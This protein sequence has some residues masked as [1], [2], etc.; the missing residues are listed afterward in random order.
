MKKFILFFGLA[1]VGIQAMDR[2]ARSPSPVLTQ[3]YS[4]FMLQ[5]AG[6]EI[7]SYGQKIATVLDYLKNNLDE[8]V[9]KKI[10]TFP[11]TELLKLHKTIKE[12]KKIKE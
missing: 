4:D 3:P 6:L 9:Y 1:I 2:D 10:I 8:P 7:D 12:S 11:E 5:H